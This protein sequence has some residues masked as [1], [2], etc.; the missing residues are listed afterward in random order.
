MSSLSRDCGPLTPRLLPLIP[1]PLP[2]R[3][4]ELC[5]RAA[6]GANVTAS[7]AL[8]DSAFSSATAD[9]LSEIAGSEEERGVNRC[10]F[11]A[12]VNCCCF[13]APFSREISFPMLTTFGQLGSAFTKKT[14]VV[15]MIWGTIWEGGGLNSESRRVEIRAA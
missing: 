11:W 10:G 4:S 7:S 2:F 3:R 1:P 12:T 5:G 13:C 15:P 14:L 9:P 6:V 8:L